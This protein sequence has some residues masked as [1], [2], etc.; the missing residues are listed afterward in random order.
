[1]KQ[2]KKVQ[3]EKTTKSSTS[4][5]YNYKSQKAKLITLFNVAFEINHI[6]LL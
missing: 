1:M 2:K 4:N 3:D 5:Y 6:E